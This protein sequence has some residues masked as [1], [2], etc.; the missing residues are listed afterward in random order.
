MCIRDRLNLPAGLP[1]G[2]SGPEISLDSG[3]TM[4]FTLN[5]VNVNQLLQSFGSEKLLPDELN[6]R[7][8]TV[9][10]TPQITAAYNGAGNSEVVIGQGRSPELLASGSDV[11]AIRDSLLALPF[12]PEDLRS[13]LASINDWQHTC[14]LY[15][16]D[17]A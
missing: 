8:F 17:A 16:S 12:L 9:V 1:G 10:M 4:N 2:Y 3:G 13:Q 6:G 7:T 15:T 5:T 11:M 14:L